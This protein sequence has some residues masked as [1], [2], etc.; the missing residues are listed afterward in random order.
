MELKLLM[1]LQPKLKINLLIVPYGIE[2]SYEPKEL[3]SLIL[4]IVPYGIE[5]RLTIHVPLLI[6]NF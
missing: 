2:T 5:T 1:E 6:L 4:L 3:L